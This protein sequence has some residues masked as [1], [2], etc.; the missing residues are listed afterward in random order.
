MLSFSRKKTEKKNVWIKDQIKKMAV[1]CDSAKRKISLDSPGYDCVG[2]LPGTGGLGFFWDSHLKYNNHS[3][4][5]LKKITMEKQNIVSFL[6]EKET[7]L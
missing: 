6:V 7:D 4:I 5:H 2:L 3:M 1:L